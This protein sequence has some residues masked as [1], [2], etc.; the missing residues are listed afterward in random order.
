[1]NPSDCSA[2][3]IGA[4]IGADDS[5]AAATP[6]MAVSFPV[7]MLLKKSAATRPSMACAA[8]SSTSGWA[9]VDGSNAELEAG[10]GH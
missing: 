6:A 2:A 3:T 9:W 10:P 8:S 5:T 4:M 7:M 1:M